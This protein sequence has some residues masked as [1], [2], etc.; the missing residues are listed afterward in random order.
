M[1]HYRSSLKEMGIEDTVALLQ[2]IKEQGLGFVMELIEYYESKLHGMDTNIGELSCQVECA[3][4]AHEK[5]QKECNMLKQENERLQ[6][7]I[8]AQKFAGQGL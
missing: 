3:C 1:P 2:E 4:S 7:E 5:L 8:P 6:K